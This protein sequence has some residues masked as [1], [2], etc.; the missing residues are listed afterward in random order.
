MTNKQRF[1]YLLAEVCEKMPHYAADMAIRA[2]YL[3]YTK[4]THRRLSHVKQGKIASLPDLIALV[5]H[6]MPNYAIPARLLPVNE[7]PQAQS[8]AQQRLPIEA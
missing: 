5:Q 1:Y 6:S 4:E 7:L 2:G 3:E 8:D